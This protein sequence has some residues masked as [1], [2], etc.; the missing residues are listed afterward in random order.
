MDVDIQNICFD[1]RSNANGDQGYVDAG[2]RAVTTPG[3][4]YVP[5]SRG[6][7]PI[8]LT[9]YSRIIVSCT[10][11]NHPDDLTGKTVT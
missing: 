4:G 6:W 1:L 8:I 3:G 9:V 2:T 11:E 7:T 10:L 5:E